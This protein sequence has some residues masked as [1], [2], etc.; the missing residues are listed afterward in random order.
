[1]A[2]KVIRR[3]NYNIIIDD[4]KETTIEQK[5][6]EVRTN[7]VKVVSKKGNEYFVKLSDRAKTLTINEMD[8]AVIKTFKECWLVTDV[9]PFVPKV[10]E[11]I[12][13]EAELKRQLQMFKDLG[14]GY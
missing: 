4:G 2:R 8:I 12:D 5:I 13:E 11:D 10:E 14:G 7:S 3:K 6:V 9:I 1:M